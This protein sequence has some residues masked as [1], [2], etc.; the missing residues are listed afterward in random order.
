MT[1]K[2]EKHTPQPAYQLRALDHV[3]I[4]TA[5]CKELAEFYSSVLGLKIGPRPNSSA[6][7]IWLY[8]G[9]NPVLHLNDTPNLT[10]DS[11]PNSSPAIH[12]FAFSALGLADFLQHLTKHKIPHHLLP[13]PELQTHLVKLSDPEGNHFEVLFNASE[14]ADLTAL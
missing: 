6:P 2:T 4:K 7:G 1:S 9:K 13:V 12:H 3:N 8:L 5:R 14:N 10:L 11:S